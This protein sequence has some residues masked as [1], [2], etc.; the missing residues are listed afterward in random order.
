MEI[1][2]TLELLNTFMHKNLMHCVCNKTLI[3]NSD[4]QE[5]ASFDMYTKY[6][7]ISRNV[8]CKSNVASLFTMI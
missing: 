1:T 5:A 8:R 6:K 3:Y 7:C 4:P 2:A